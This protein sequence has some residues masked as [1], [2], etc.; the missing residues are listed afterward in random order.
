MVNILGNYGLENKHKH[1]TASEN[2]ISST[3]QLASCVVFYPRFS[4]QFRE[5]VSVFG[6]VVSIRFHSS[7][8]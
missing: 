7:C 5:A 1:I 6:Y 3:G 2:I 4:A 8:C